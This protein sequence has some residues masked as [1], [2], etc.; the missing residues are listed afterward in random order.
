MELKPCPF[1]GG[2]AE[3]RT[4]KVKNRITK[5]QLLGQRIALYYLRCKKCR[6]KTNLFYD[7]AI[8]IHE[9]NIGRIH[10]T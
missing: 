9:W 1:C 8:V 5:K 10:K 4:K 7:I 3:I 2:Q 6:A